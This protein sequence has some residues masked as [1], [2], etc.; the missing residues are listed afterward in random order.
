M[1][2]HL[3]RE[4]NSLIIHN[5]SR[6]DSSFKRWMKQ[7]NAKLRLPQ[8]VYVMDYYNDCWKQFEQLKYKIPE[9]VRQNVTLRYYMWQKI[10]KVYIPEELKTDLF[11]FQIQGLYQLEAGF[12]YLADKMG[13]GKTPQALRFLELHKGNTNNLV[14]CPSYMKE[15]WQAEAKRWT[16]LNTQII[17][18]QKPN[19]LKDNCTYIINYEILQYHVE[20]L[21][22]KKLDIVIADEIH[23]CRNSN[24][25]RTKSV[26]KVSKKANRFITLSGTPFVNNPIEI[27]P[28]LSSIDNFQFYSKALFTD[29]YCIMSKMYNKP[30]GSKNEEDLYKRLKKSIMIRRT[31]SD[32]KDEMKGRFDTK[33][34]Q[35]VMP[36]KISNYAEYKRAKKDD[37]IDDLQKPRI[38]KDIIYEGKKK[39]IFE[40]VDNFLLSDEKIGLFFKSTA[41]LNEFVDRYKKVSMKIDG[42]TPT[43]VRFDMCSKFNTDDRIKVFCGNIIACGT[44]LDLIGSHTVCFIDLDWN[45]NNMEQV[46]SRFNR[47]GQKSPIV[48]VVYFV[49]MDTIESSRLLY[50]LDHKTR[51]F[52]KVIDNEEIQGK[53][54]FVKGLKNENC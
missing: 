17:S 33:V 52:T 42:S 26:K 41:H 20:I 47:F 22:R 27:Y 28:I 9:Y 25:I 29:Q 48:N 21:K 30:C 46:I 3:T 49:G 37:S 10:K 50:N 23:M 34:I 32:V 39:A 4:G 38:L 8:G 54:S 35:D 14:I 6:T 16:T 40:Y 18:G 11:G 43:K 31:I 13:L 36:L 7:L 19:E 12:S 51:Q 2:R 5:T 44:G 45:Y 24:T 53:E 15:K 1:A